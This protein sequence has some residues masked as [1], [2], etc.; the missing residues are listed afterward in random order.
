METFLQK[1]LNI[2]RNVSQI[3]ENNEVV[4]VSNPNGLGPV[5]ILCEHASHHIPAR[6]AGLGLSDAVRTSHAAW[7]PGALAVSR[8]L[9]DALDAPLVAGK[10][11]RLVYDCNRPPE[12]PGAMAE[13]SEIY[14]I[15]GNRGLSAAQK[16]ERVE[17]VYAPFC[18]AVSEV[19]DR[20]AV[21]AQPTA[22]VTIHS[23]TPVYLGVSR[24]V[25]LGILHD[26]DQ[27]LADAMLM[28]AEKVQQLNIQRNQ[29]YGPEDGVTHSLKIHAIERGLPNVMIEF[30][31]DLVETADQVQSMAQDVLNLLRPALMRLGML[32]MGSAHG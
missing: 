11:S 31:N 24:E 3:H 28:Q 19:L 20:R 22:V 6:Y 12:A 15:P 9:S 10:V 17:H 8:I 29:P 21:N 4:E 7:D 18:A 13:K 25:E 16:A 23:F 26:S 32:E 27:E 30:R 1:L 14:E 2:R 5:V